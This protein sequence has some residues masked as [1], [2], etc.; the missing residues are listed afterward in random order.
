[1]STPEGV[2]SHKEAQERGLGGV[3]IGYVY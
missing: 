1:V 2:M 3:L